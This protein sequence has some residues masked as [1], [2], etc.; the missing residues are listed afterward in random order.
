M[1]KI[2]LMELQK[3]YY[4]IKIKEVK[5]NAFINGMRIGIF[6]LLVWTLVH[7]NLLMR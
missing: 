4:D 6:V 7:F 1:D 5:M 2:S 3:D